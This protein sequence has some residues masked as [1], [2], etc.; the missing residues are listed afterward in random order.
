MHHENPVTHRRRRGPGPRGGPGVGVEVSKLLRAT[1]QHG[2]LAS[3]RPRCFGSLS[4]FRGSGSPKPRMTT[5]LP[6][7]HPA[8]LTA[9]TFAFL[10]RRPARSGHGWPLTRLRVTYPV[11]AASRG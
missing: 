6:S 9:F 4:T 11:R 2:D 5:T 10:T 1:L 7:I 8:Y 3:H